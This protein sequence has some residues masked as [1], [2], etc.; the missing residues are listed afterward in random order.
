MSDSL[1]F[2]LI[3]DGIRWQFYGAACG[4]YSNT[5]IIRNTFRRPLTA[6]FRH[7]NGVISVLFV[8][9]SNHHLVGITLRGNGDTAL[10]CIRTF[11]YK[12]LL[13][14]GKRRRIVTCNEAGFSLE[15]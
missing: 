12:W 4:I 10:L 1:D 7:G 5:L 8:F 15:A 3:P 11:S 13:R 14:I 9:I 2:R 6:C